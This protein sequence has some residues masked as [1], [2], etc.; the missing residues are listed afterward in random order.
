VIPIKDNIATGRFPFVTVGLIVANLVVYILAIQ[1]GGSFISGPSTIETFKYGVIPYAILHPGAHC[2]H[3]VE[4]A[5]GHH[6]PAQNLLPSWLTIFTGMFMHASIVQLAGNMIFLGI[7]GPSVE[8][9][10]GPLKYICFYV[11][12]GLASLALQIALAPHAA[13]PTVGAAG[14]VGA[15]LGGYVLIYPQARVL[16]FAFIIL[17]VTVIELPVWVLLGAWVAEQAAFA[18][19]GLIN[20]V[21]TG[22]AAAYF[23]YAGGFLFGL[24][25]IRLLAG[26]VKRIAPR[27]PQAVA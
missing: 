14:A 17:F 27:R 4:V 1:H 7:F 6:L 16:T 3:L 11:L 21:G 9:A 13:G 2:A 23:A 22:R 24:V 15:V 19:T 18:A 12:G 5:C 25:T 10:M 20:P 26:N 8:D